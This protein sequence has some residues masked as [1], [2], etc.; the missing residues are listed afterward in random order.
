MELEGD[1][2]VDEIIESAATF[3]N[4]DMGAYVL[5]K[6]KKVLRGGSSIKDSGIIAEDVLEL[7]P[8]PEGG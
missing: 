1:N 6:G 4:K 5:R 7:I 3:W 2:T 8:D